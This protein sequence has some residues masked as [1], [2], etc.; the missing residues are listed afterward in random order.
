MENNT[1]P[2]I[3]LFIPCYMDQF[4]P[5]V[6]I[7]TLEVLEKLG[8]QVTY[9][10]NQT[11][12]GQPMANAGFERD[13][14]GTTKHFIETFAAYDYVV[15]PSGSCVLHV[16]EH[17][18]KAQGLEKEQE[19]LHNK[20]FEFTEFLTDILG[21][22]KLEGSF[23]HRIGYHASCQ[24]QR[25]L[26]LSSS[27]EL[28]EKPFSKAKKL[29]ENLEGLKW[30]ELARTDE[31]CGFGGTFAVSEEALSVQMGKDRLEDHISH[32]VEILTGSDM[33]C[34]M[35]LQGIAQRQKQSI[36]FKHIAEIL[37]QILK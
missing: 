17:S 31:C 12:C 24:G 23:P 29:L 36:K 8:C 18:P 11:C 7:A 15:C 22:E 10:M 14:L 19:A 32:Q 3:A 30:V 1:K 20:I 35:H 26:R 5:K 9:P 25:G 27:S 33:S 16:K 37:N 34:I 2:Q 6:A 28:N 21:V 4:Y 13:T